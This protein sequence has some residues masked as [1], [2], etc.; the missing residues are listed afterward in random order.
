MGDSNLLSHAL[1]N[2]GVFVDLRADDILQPAVNTPLQY[3]RTV[4][5]C[6]F[7]RLDAYNSVPSK[8]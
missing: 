4:E 8:L 5:I 1:S 2:I 3:Q 7:T 6:K